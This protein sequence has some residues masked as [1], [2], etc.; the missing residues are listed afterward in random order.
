MAVRTPMKRIRAKCLD[1]SAGSRRE[2]KLC[3]SPE[4]LLY[5]LRFGRRPKD[6]DLVF[7]P[8]TDSYRARVGGGR[9][10]NGGSGAVKCHQA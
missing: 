3:V 1:C 2:V 5:D 9:W 8:E 6:D 7:D 4:C 10:P